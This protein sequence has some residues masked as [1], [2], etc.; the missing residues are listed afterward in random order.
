M[1]VYRV[2]LQEDD[3]AGVLQRHAHLVSAEDA[4]DAARMAAAHAAGDPLAAWDGADAT[5]VPA[6]VTAA[7]ANA[8][9]G[10]RFQVTVSEPTQAEG[11]AT[12]AVHD[13]E[14]TGDATDDTLDEVGAALAALLV[15]SGLTA[16]YTGATQTLEVAAIADAVGDHKVDVLVRPPA[17]LDGSDRVNIEGFVA[18]ITDEGI[19]AAVLEVVFAADTFIVPV[20]LQSYRRV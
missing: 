15:T 2:E 10:W 11:L 19:P 17:S 3:K 1:P 12:V 4:T 5:L 14:F 9:V 6:D 16:T 18:S 13:V 20:I 8:M 7:T